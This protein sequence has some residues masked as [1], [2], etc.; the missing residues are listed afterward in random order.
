MNRID[1]HDL[2]TL[3]AYLDKQLSSGERTAF[4]QRLA[5]EPA[6]QQ[7]LE[8]LRATVALLKQIEPLRAPR[9]FTLDPKVYGVPKRR[10]LLDRLGLLGIPQLVT[11]GGALAATLVCAGLVFYAIQGGNFGAATGAPEAA[12]VE[13]ERMA[14]DTAE[15]AEEME[16]ASAALEQSA[17]AEGEP[18][19][20]EESADAAAL[21]PPSQ[22]D[23]TEPPD[24]DPLYGIDVSG[25]GGGGEGGGAGGAGGSGA[26]PGVAGNATAEP[27]IT[28]LQATEPPAGADLTAVAEAAADGDAGA[29][30]DSEMPY[31]GEDPSTK[32]PAPGLPVVPLAIGTLVVVLAAGSF[33]VY[34]A[35]R[36]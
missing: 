1:E 18:A 34:R 32:V 29:Q 24:G 21:A 31:A 2:I 25:G 28:I 35:R 6:L 17:P 33:I 12:M 7:E 36:R 22:E 19:A 14:G 3:N 26:G 5:K 20:E 13:Q 27:T 30:D 23:L 8:S 10:S 4:E 9:N 11:A 15:Q 16:A